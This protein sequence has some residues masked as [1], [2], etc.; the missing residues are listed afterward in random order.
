MANKIQEPSIS[1]INYINNKFN[2]TGS[3]VFIP[4]KHAKPT[5]KNR[6]SEK[7]RLKI[8]ISEDP[9][10]SIRKLSVELGVSYNLTRDILRVDLRLKP[11]K[12]GEKHELKDQDY[13]KRLELLIG[14]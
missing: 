11:Y 7:Q 6:R 4:H 1:T 9:T 3:V 10:L 12:Y 13:Q 2:K 14:S 8:I 5:T